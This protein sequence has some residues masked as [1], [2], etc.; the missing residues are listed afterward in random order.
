MSGHSKWATIKHKKASTDAKR[1]RI[2]TR[3]IKEITVAARSGGG[4]PDAN[5]RLRAAMAAAKAEN[6]PAENIKRA[7][8]RGTGELPGVNYEETSYEGYG[9]HG[10][11]MLVQVA[12]DNKN[13]T[14]ADIRHLFSKFG[15]NMGEDGCVAWIFQK[16]GTITVPQR[17]ASED[18]ILAIVLKAGAEDLA[19]DGDHWE[20]LTSPEALEAV[21][22]ALKEAGVE[23]SNAEVSM[24]PQTTVK[25]EGRSAEQMIRFME[26]LEDHEDVQNVYSNFDI[27]AK[28]LE[29][30]SGE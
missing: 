15:G 23:V 9:P 17:R 28:E 13:R 30:V 16:Q 12:T 11:A 8:K 27:D 19:D 10:V 7:V 4:D 22:Q 1:G 3:V 6:M 5:P 24:I 29:R 20:I 18:D 21:T 25:L 26:T 14:V 2:F